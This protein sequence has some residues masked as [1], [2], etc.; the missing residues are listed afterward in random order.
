MEH[1]RFATEFTSSVF[2]SSLLRFLISASH[3]KRDGGVYFST[4]VP[5]H[6]SPPVHVSIIMGPSTR[7]RRSTVKAPLSPSTTAATPAR[8]SPAEAKKEESGLITPATTA[9][10]SDYDDELLMLSGT[11]ATSAASSTRRQVE[12][13]VPLLGLGGGS[14]R[15]GWSCSPP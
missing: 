2:I 7:P 3:T 14:K 15:K 5:P 1:R 6:I 12:V 4:S 10:A 13:A 11:R 8:A 9:A